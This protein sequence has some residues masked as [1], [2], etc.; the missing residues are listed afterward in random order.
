MWLSAMK[1]ACIMPIYHGY[2]KL[3]AGVF[4]DNG[5]KSKDGFLG[6]VCVEI[7]RLNPG[8]TYDVTI[9]LRLSTSVYSRRKLGAVRLRLTLS[10]LDRRG[11]L[12]S[13]FP[14]RRRRAA[15]GRAATT[16]ACADP[17]AF[18]AVALAVH[19]K[20]LPGKFSTESL[21]AT[22]REFAFVQQ[23]VMGLVQ[24]F[25]RDLI[26][27]KYPVVSC[28]AFVGWMRC[29]WSGLNLAPVY[30]LSLVLLQLVRNY[31]RYV[32]NDDGEFRPTA[33]LELLGG[34][35]HAALFRAFGLLKRDEFYADG[36][37][38]YT[39]QEFPFSSLAGYPR[40]F[41]E[42]AIAEEK[43]S[44]TGTDTAR[45][46]ES[47]NDL[48][49]F[50]PKTYFKKPLPEQNMDKKIETKTK[51][52]TLAE[53]LLEVEEKAH[54][55]TLQL[56]NDNHAYMI[57]D[58]T[59]APWGKQQRREKNGEEYDVKRDLDKLLG[60]GQFSQWNPIV[61]KFTV[62]IEPIARVF[63][64][65]L[66]AYRSAYNIFTWRDPFL[67]FW[68]TLCCIFAIV[69]L[70]FFPWRMAFIVVGLVAL[71]PQN[72]AIRVIGEIRSRRSKGGEISGKAGSLG[73]F[74][75][76]FK[77]EDIDANLPEKM[78]RPTNTQHDL[79]PQ[80]LFQ[81]HK[82]KRENLAIGVQ[83]IR[84]PYTPLSYHRFYD[85]PP[86][87]TYS[88]VVN[89]TT[90]D[91][92]SIYATRD[93]SVIVHE[94]PV[95]SKSTIEK[96]E[97]TETQDPPVQGQGSGLV[98]IPTIKSMKSTTLP[99]TDM[100][101]QADNLA[102]MQLQNER[103]VPAEKSTT[104][105]K[106]WSRAFAAK[107]DQV[108]FSLEKKRAQLKEGIVPEDE[109]VNSETKKS[110]GAAFMTRRINK[111]AEKLQA[112]RMKLGAEESEQTITDDN[113]QIL[114]E[115]PDDVDSYSSI[116]IT[117]PPGGL[118]LRIEASS[119][120]GS[121]V[122]QINNS[123]PLAGI[124]QL[125]DKVVAIDDEDVSKLSSVG[126]SK[127]LDSRSENP[128]RKITVLRNIVGG[129]N[130]EHETM[131]HNLGGKDTET[132][133]VSKAEGGDE[134]SF[135]VDIQEV[136]AVAGF[137]EEKAVTSMEG[138][139]AI[140]QAN[141]DGSISPEEEAQ[142][143][144][145][146][147]TIDDFDQQLPT[148]ED[149]TMDTIDDVDQQLPGFDGET[150]DADESPANHEEPINKERVSESLAAQES[151]KD[152]NIA[153]NMKAMEIPASTTDDTADLLCEEL[154]SV[155][156]ELATARTEN[157]HFRDL[158]KKK[159]EELEMLRNK[160]LQY[161]KQPFNKLWSKKK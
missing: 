82:T 149:K 30:L 17:K 119:K 105:G 69:V 75:R 155:K 15:A 16:V 104:T 24:K 5:S 76:A 63:E 156:L 103:D 85:W 50:D 101:S 148:V 86:D 120:G 135:D 150:M 28:L 27:W 157:D 125:M 122:A 129:G 57:T 113:D 10:D 147:D 3:Y 36:T 118:G 115:S 11:M 39:N 1:R 87:P 55:F 140:E 33:I 141:D 60:L 112:K 88:R 161:E 68:V 78:H 59:T 41:V 128:A 13:Y 65:A 9:P 35:S 158:L 159:D 127:L 67:S 71:G 14:G 26:R 19:G 23:S 80:P 145:P 160:C 138:I 70:L 37:D 92:S 146:V 72:L 106:T 100:S 81:Y 137:P 64:V 25:V 95:K 83:H 116:E 99:S 77:D 51:D 18:R 134:H 38:T 53:E 79:C 31:A 52:K 153:L 42:E 34:I 49:A 132:N 20:H 7:G 130:N 131:V 58:T 139:D 114:C 46:T 94:L 40:L 4:H 22:I 124:I 48:V 107:K 154:M 108:K 111:L 93:E 109:S 84:I 98:Q 102:S 44:E 117:A 47:A 74:L 121:E 56:F 45:A 142:C 2:A 21:T 143:I 110:A 144:P 43:D 91:P 133:D 32:V 152:I 90:L 73:R 96:G 61:S 123:S 12:L 126:V 97:S 54:K 8:R 136:F 6:R 89:E 66:F 151:N 29:A 62:Q